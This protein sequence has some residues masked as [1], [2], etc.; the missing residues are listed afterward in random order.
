MR[1]AVVPAQYLQIALDLAT[2]IAR[3]ELA[4]GSRIYGRS[5]MAS[6]YGVS[7]ETIRRAP[8]WG[9]TSTTFM[10][11]SSRRALAPA[12][13][14][15]GGSGFGKGKRIV[16]EI[17]ACAVAAAV[18]RL[19]VE[20]NRE[21]PPDLELSLIHILSLQLTICMKNLTR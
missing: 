7:P 13:R 1:Q 8:L 18:R 3:G 12:G 5:V 14:D 21:L 6:E 11:A 15:T 17:R 4:E 19:C 20:A 2:R 16:R 10:S 9:F